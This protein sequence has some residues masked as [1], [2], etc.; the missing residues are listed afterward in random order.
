VKK[1]ILIY[2]ICCGLLILV[3]RLV[4]YRFLI[5]DNKL[6]LYGGAVALIFVV[7]GI[8]FGSKLAKKKEVIVVKEIKVKEDVPFILNEENLK[9]VGMSKREYE[10]LEQVAKGLS[11]K[12]IADTLSVSENTIKTHT[13]RIFEKLNVNRRMQAIQRAKEM[14]LLP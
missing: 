9:S 10:I 12:E 8:W 4:E 13:S 5:I 3:L 7:L 2:G 6:E 14:G 11:N 1:D